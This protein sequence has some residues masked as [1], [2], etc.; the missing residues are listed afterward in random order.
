VRHY[1][2]QGRFAEAEPLYRDVIR[3]LQSTLGAEHPSV[4]TAL[5]NL[6]MVGGGV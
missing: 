1:Y 3:A 5:N 4:L 2:T 6:A